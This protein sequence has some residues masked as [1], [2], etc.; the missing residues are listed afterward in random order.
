MLENFGCVG[1][2]VHSRR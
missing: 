1:D 2:H